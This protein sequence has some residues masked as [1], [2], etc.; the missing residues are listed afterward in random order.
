MRMSSS[1]VAPSAVAILSTALLCSLTGAAMS[2]TTPNSSLPSVTVEAPKQTVRPQREERSRGSGRVVHRGRTSRSTQLANG[3]PSYAR[4]SVMYK[5]AKL[6]REASSCNDGCESSFRHGKD[7]WV[8]CSESAGWYTVFSATCKD[9]LTHKDYVQCVETEMLQAG[10][11]NEPGGDAPACWP[12]AN[13]GSPHKIE[14]GTHDSEARYR[15]AEARVGQPDRIAANVVAANTIWIEDSIHPTMFNPGPLWVNAG[16]GRS[17]S[18]TGRC[19]SHLAVA[20]QT[21]SVQLSEKANADVEKGRPSRSR[22]Q[23]RP[24]ASMPLRTRR[25][26]S[27][28]IKTVHTP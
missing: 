4:G 6:E 22:C 25:V 11:A 1:L 23:D 24:L 3:T 5:L 28:G 16:I 12:G 17:M 19:L 2:Q 13:S 10:N 21:A 27:A 15:T 8:G 7:P 9:T 18:A 20:P 14:T 26:P